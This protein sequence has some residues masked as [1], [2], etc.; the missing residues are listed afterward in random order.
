MFGCLKRH[1]SGLG[2][3]GWGMVLILCGSSQRGVTGNSDLD[4]AKTVENFF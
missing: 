4:D 1:V 2:K 3:R